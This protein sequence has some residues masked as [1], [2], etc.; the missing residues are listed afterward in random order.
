MENINEEKVYKFI[1]N[2][3]PEIAFCFGWSQLIKDNI[4]K[5]IPQGIIGFHPAALPKNRGRHPI[6]WALVLGLQE[7]ASTFFMMDASAD[8]GDIVSQKI[9]KISYE[10]DAA[11]LYQKIMTIACEQVVE[12]WEQLQN[13]TANKIKLMYN[14]AFRANQFLAAGIKPMFIFNDM[15]HLR[16]EFYGFMPIFPIEKN[17]QNKAFYGK[18]FSKVE[19]MGEVSVI[20]QLPF[21]A[22]SAYVNHYSSPRREWNVGLSIGWQ[23]FNYRFIE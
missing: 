9:V 11:T 6:I 22:I 21:G 19:Y 8:T 17:T 5:K 4:I 14:E 3:Q 16:G 23:L 7:T 12:L 1:E 20:C 18:A 13:G 2:I 10:D 15:F